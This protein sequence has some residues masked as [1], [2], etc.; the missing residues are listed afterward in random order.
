MGLGDIVDGVFR[1]VRANAAA[2]AP[3]LVLF[4]LPFYAFI[5]YEKAKGPTIGQLFAN[6]GTV[7]ETSSSATD[8]QL[9]AELGLFVAMGV[10]AGAVCRT[11]SAS[12]KGEHLSVGQ[13]IRLSPRQWLA[14]LIAS[15][16]GHLLEF[17]GLVLCVLPGLTFM[18]FFF[19]TAPAIVMEGLG[20]IEGLRRSLRLVSHQFWRV[21]GIMLLGCLL[22]YLVVVIIELVP[23]IVSAAVASAHAQA[24]IGAVVGTLGA[25]LEWALFANLGAL[26]YFDQRIRQEGLDLEV[27]AAR[28]R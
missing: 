2:L 14:L 24:V 9:L 22:I 27:M 1:L 19:L 16:L 25:S 6:L 8:W 7:Q 5:S 21:L 4:A 10:A 17:V 3:V 28:A 23:D 11:V 26:L 15:I 13:A 12:Y 18:A 20:P